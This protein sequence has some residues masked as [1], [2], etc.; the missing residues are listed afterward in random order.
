MAEPKVTINI[1]E[2]SPEQRSP[3]IVFEAFDS[4]APGESLLII[5][6]HDPEML[7]SRLAARGKFT[8]TYLEQGPET[9]RFEITKV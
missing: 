9:W 1:K 3:H 2:I 5:N 4:L 7:K 8:W 6:D